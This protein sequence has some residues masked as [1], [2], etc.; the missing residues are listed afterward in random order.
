MD[1]EA[2]HMHNEALPREEIHS[3]TVHHSSASAPDA[4]Y[5]GVS[6]A[7]AKPNI[8]L[9]NKRISITIDLDGLFVV[10]FQKTDIQLV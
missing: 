7:A 3:L 10:Q 2:Y 5:D 8:P 4:S 9:Q 1:A 6:I